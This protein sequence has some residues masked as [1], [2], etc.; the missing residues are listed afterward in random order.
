MLSRLLGLA[1]RGSFLPRAKVVSHFA[2]AEEVPKHEGDNGY[3]DPG[4]R[5]DSQG[6]IDDV[7]DHV[8]EEAGHAEPVPP[9]PAPEEPVGRRRAGQTDAGEEVRRPGAHAGEALTR[10]R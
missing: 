2:G 7:A 4:T 6:R 3:A 1:S 10:V 8:D 5:L 9:A